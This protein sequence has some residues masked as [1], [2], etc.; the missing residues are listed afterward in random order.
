[1][2][3]RDITEAHVVTSMPSSRGRRQYFANGEPVW[4]PHRRAF[5]SY[6]ENYEALAFLADRDRTFPLDDRERNAAVYRSLVPTPVEP[7]DT[8]R[9]KLPYSEVCM[10]MR[11]AGQVRPVTVHA[12]GTA[13]I[14]DEAGAPFS[15]PV[16]WGEAGIYSNFR[17]SMWYHPPSPL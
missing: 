9:L 12:N 4:W 14:L 7:G 13:Q 15:F 16:S 17:G 1:M 6:V 11:V 5:H 10:H 2:Y 8:V 3:W